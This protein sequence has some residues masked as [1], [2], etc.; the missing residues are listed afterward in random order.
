LLLSALALSQTATKPAAKPAAPVTKAPPTQSGKPAASTAKPPETKPAA[1]SDEI[2]P[3]AAVITISGI[4]N[5]K[6]PATPSPDCNTTVSRAA[7]EKL[8]DAFDP[9]MPVPRRQQLADAY[10][11]MIVMS[12]AAEQRGLDKSADAQEVLRFTRMQILSQL[13]LRDLQ[14]DAANVP[15]ADAQKY[16]DEHAPQYE[17]ATLLR[18]F[19]P[20]TPPGGEKPADEKTL[21]AEGEKLRAAAASGGDFEK[22]QKQA[23]DD[24]GIKTPPPPTS[25]GTLRRDNLQQNQAKVFDLQPGQVSEVIDDPGGLYIF[26][27]ESKKKLTLAEATPEINRALESERMKAALEKVTGSIKPVFN[28]QYFGVAPAAGGPAA[29]GMPARRPAVPGTPPAAAPPPRPP[30]R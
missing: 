2:P 22:L 28:E 6:V 29:P 26:K 18:L 27:V 23:Y 13:L 14:K 21:Q 4:C 8:V 20:K 19:I 12:D 10:V 16:Y 30:Q 25:G 3:T 1:T 24:L 7:F 17:Q 11:R 9:R 5:G 15:A